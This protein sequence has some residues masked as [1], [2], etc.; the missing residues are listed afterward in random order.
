MTY[1]KEAAPTLIFPA[2]AAIAAMPDTT[3]AGASGVSRGPTKTLEM[4]SK[5]VESKKL[6]HTLHRK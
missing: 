3:G 5:D 2:N 4:I 1:P 6:W